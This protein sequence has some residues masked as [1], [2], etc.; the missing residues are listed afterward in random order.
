MSLTTGTRL[1]PYQILSPVGAC[2]MGEVYKASNTR[3]DRVVIVNRPALLRNDVGAGLGPYE[4][5]EAWLATAW[6][7]RLHGECT[8]VSVRLVS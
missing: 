8:A 2:G 7:E 1:G 6:Y 3:L 4:I 5:P